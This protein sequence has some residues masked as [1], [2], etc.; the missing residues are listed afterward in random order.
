MGCSPANQLAI[1][2]MKDKDKETRALMKSLPAPSGDEHPASTVNAVTRSSCM[3]AVPDGN[4]AWFR[5]PF[6]FLLLCATSTDVTS[7]RQ[8]L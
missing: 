5:A 2:I 3:S 7:H 1:N 4:H 6:L 8:V